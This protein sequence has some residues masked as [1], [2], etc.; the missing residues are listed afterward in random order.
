MSVRFSIVFCLVAMCG[1]NSP[2]LV[3]FSR[4]ERLGKQQRKEL[5]VYYESWLSID[6]G[7]MKRQIQSLPVQQL[8]ADKIVC[9]LEESYEPNVRYVAQYGV[10]RYPAVILVHRDG[11][12]HQRTGVMSAEGITNF[13]KTAAPPGQQPMI[14]PQIPREIDYDWEADYERAFEIAEQQH[15]PVFIF[16]K[17]VV[18]ADANEMFGTLDRPD[19]AELFDDT[20]N[21]LLDWG[22]APNRRF[23]TQ[24][25]VTNVPALVIVNPDGTHHARQGRMTAAQ[26]ISFVRTAKVSRR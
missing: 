9:I 12:Y 13:L 19:V 1:C 5:F 22:Y 21:C 17:S 7:E 18:S 11:T 16:Y 4:A 2:V 15:R 6:C 10:H 8:L 20:V 26:V 3:N 14:N 23:M 25:G 24:Y